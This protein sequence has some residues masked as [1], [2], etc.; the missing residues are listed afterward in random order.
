[1]KGLVILLGLCL[2]PAANPVSTKTVISLQVSDYRDRPIA[3]VVLSAKANGSISHPTDAAGKTEITITKKLQPGEMIILLLV[4]TPSKDL[5]FL[6]PW[7]G[8]GVVPQ[9]PDAIEIVLGKLGDPGALTNSKVLTSL[10][11]EVNVKSG[12]E[13]APTENSSH[14]KSLKALNKVA[15]GLKLAPVAVDRAI[16]KW[17]GSTDDP[18]QRKTGEIYLGHLPPDAVRSLGKDGVA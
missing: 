12:D 18:K 17:A 11:E 14:K 1:M 3:G 8:H 2:V 9:P 10:A 16:R 6:A 7:E 4:S 15:E 13:T 5:Q